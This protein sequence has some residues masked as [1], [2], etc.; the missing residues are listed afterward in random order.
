MSS[1][2]AAGV[3]FYGFSRTSVSG[4][5][6]PMD[7]AF[8]GLAGCY[9][10]NSADDSMPL[11]LPS[12]SPF[13]TA[14]NVVIPNDSYFLGMDVYFQALALEGSGF[15]RFATVTNGVEAHIG[16]FVEPIGPPSALNMVRIDAGTFQMGSNSI[17]GT[18]I[19]VHP[20]TIS[21]SFWIGRYEVT[22]AEYQSVMGVNPSA[23]QGMPQHPVTRVSWSSAM[24]YCASLTALEVAAGRVLPGYHYRLPTEA[25]WEYC[26]RA[27]TITEWNTGSSLTMSDA[28]ISGFPNGQTTPVGS[29]APNAWGL[30]DMHGNVVEWCL[31]AWDGLANYVPSAVVDP[32]VANGSVGL[33]RGGGWT[34]SASFCRSAFRLYISRSTT[35][36]NNG[37]RVVLA[38]VVVP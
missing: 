30:Y 32:Y 7:L 37:F 9:A 10:Y 19:P 14:W 3:G 31:D 33:G 36:V 21:R 16:E 2:F 11:G 35:Y 20:V 29:Y 18:A 1:P 27:G 23:L 8:V 22:Q 28:N 38:P 12:A 4:I 6:L 24:A 34:E 5:P 13:V 17:G 15:P 25:E 26:C